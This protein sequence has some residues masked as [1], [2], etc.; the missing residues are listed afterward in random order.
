M[1]VNPAV[2]HLRGVILPQADRRDLFVVDGHITF[3]PPDG[4]V[5]T[6]LEDG[7]LIPGLVDMHAHLALASPA[8]AEASSEE[9]VRAS[10]R[11]Q[12]EAGV[13]AIR[14]PGGPDYASN[15]LGPHEHL[16]RVYTAGR[17]LA[18]AGR[19][20]PGL[21]REAANEELAEAAEDEARASRAWAKVIGD[22]VS[23]DGQMLPNYRPEALAEAARRV[24]ALGA[25]IAIH[26][27]TPEAI[28]GAIEAGFDSIEHGWNLQEDHIRAMA[29]RG[30]ALVP[31]L[32]LVPSAPMW[33]P[34]MGLTPSILRAMLEGAKRQPEMARRAMESGVLVLAG[35][36]AG[37][38][39]HGMIREEISLM[40]AAGVPQE[41][42]LAAGSWVARQFL[43]LPGLEEGAPADIVAYPDDPRGNPEVLARPSLRILDGQLIQS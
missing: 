6:I 24:H 22:W 30:I 14:E 15:K 28:E 25:R 35:T 1:Q 27:N 32:T 31:T 39:P 21:S 26:A 41:K 10:A 43:G 2:L 9:K 20:F 34:Q 18:P 16:P 23:P 5:T 7:Y 13:L 11:A 33:M 12:L 38:G 19:Y 29:A 3:N 4:P 42:V 36:D 17:F 37:M 40:L 8:P